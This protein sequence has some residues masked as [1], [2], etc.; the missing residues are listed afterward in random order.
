LDV[1]LRSKYDRNERKRKEEG[2]LD[3]Q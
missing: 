1:V 3:E 2:G